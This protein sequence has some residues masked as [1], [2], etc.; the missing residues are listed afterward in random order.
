[1]KVIVISIISGLLG[2]AGM[3]IVMSFIHSAKFVVLNLQMQ[4]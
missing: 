2:A 3:G 1:M 4:I